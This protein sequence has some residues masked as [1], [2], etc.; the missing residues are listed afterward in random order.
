MH[1]TAPLS[2]RYRGFGEDETSL[3]T[4][5]S[6]AVVP[7]FAPP[8]K[9]DDHDL[10]QQFEVEAFASWRPSVCDRFMV[11]YDQKPH[12][13]FCQDAQ[14]EARKTLHTDTPSSTIPARYCLR[15]DEART[16]HGLS[17]LPAPFAPSRNL[18]EISFD[19]LASVL[20]EEYACCSG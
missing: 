2:C 15:F 11:G 17:C 18:P 5:I 4:A 3:Y 19:D 14:I 6:H 9:I 16:Q 7:L 8:Y 10:K 20:V 12:A 13:E 1:I